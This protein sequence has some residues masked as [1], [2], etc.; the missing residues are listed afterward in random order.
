MKKNFK[1]KFVFFCAGCVLGLAIG[2]AYNY[3]KSNGAEYY[4][5]KNDYCISNKGVIKS[6]TLVKFD[7]AMPENFSRYIL[8]LNIHDGEEIMKYG[9]SK[10]GLI[11]PYWL[12]PD[13]DS[14]C[15]KK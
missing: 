14:A 15:V 4:E 1:L 10:R 5:L 13:Y 12:N 8:Y 2:I 11:V 6:G 7:K 3:L 9:N